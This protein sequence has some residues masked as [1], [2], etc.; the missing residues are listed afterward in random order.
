MEDKKK[1]LLSLQLDVKD[2]IPAS[3]DEK[4]S[5]VIMR[6]SVGFWKDGIRRFRK[7]KIAMTSL[8]IVLLIVFICFIVGNDDVFVVRL[9]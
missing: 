2:F 4:Q 9:C 5:L 8:I 7:N 1:N 6:E 3:A